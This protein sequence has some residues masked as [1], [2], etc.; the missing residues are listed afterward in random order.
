MQT[1]TRTCVGGNQ[2]DDGCQGNNYKNRTCNEKADLTPSC[3][4][5]KRLGFCEVT[6]KHFTFVKRKCAKTCC[7][8][9]EGLSVLYIYMFFYFIAGAGSFFS[10]RASFAEKNP[11]VTRTKEKKSFTDH[12][13]FEKFYYKIKRYIL[14]QM[15]N[16]INI[17]LVAT[18][19]HK[20]KKSIFVKFYYKNLILGSSAL[21]D[22]QLKR[23]SRARHFCL[24]GRIWPS[25]RM[26]VTL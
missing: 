11:S 17:K 24:A 4:I 21:V 12:S 22:F 16:E 3:S 26:L 25:S 20:Q 2:G 14:T 5:Y 23:A 7:S 13:I 18:F 19:T 1:A 8:L 9:Y 10:R 6:S 15:C